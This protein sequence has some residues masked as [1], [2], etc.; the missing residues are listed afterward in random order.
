MAA[1]TI[2]FFMT[3]QEFFDFVR[4][5]LAPMDLE[6]IRAKDGVWTLADQDHPHRPSY[7]APHGGERPA[8]VGVRSGREGW[9]AATPPIVAGTTLYIADI[10][11]RPWWMDPKTGVKTAMPELERLFGRVAR[12]LRK[13]L[14]FSVMVSSLSTHESS[15]YKS[16]GHSEGARAWLKNSGKWRQEGVENIG[17]DLP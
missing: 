8:A 12:K 7:L 6:L 16:I 3:L 10:S 17:Y 5:D 13:R 9:I 14:E 4:V 2:Q 1:R 11:V 15:V